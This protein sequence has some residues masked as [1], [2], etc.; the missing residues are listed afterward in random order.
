MKA[1]TEDYCEWCAGDL[2]LSWGRHLSEGACHC[3]DM[4][5]NGTSLYLQMFCVDCK[6]RVIYTVQAVEVKA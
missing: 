4:G 2:V 6:R 3:A 1:I 5:F